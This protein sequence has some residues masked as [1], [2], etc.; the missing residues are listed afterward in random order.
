M[1]VKPP[2]KEVDRE[3]VKELEEALVDTVT[4][5]AV[6]VS[7]ITK[8][9]EDQEI[10][11]NKKRVKA[12]R[13]PRPLKWAGST[14]KVDII[15]GL[16]FK[17]FSIERVMKY[18]VILFLPLKPWVTARNETFF[19][20]GNIYPGADEEDIVFFR[21]LWKI[22][23]AMTKAEK[24]TIWKFWDTQIGIVEDWLEAT[25]WVVNDKERLVIPDIDYVEEAKR[26][27]ALV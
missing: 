27:G 23:N 3:Y 10:A 24:D 7:T 12:G 17:L 18:N 15:S 8:S 20:K 4:R 1:D 26:V 19:L 21:N 14:A 6:F 13:N 9:L 2:T 25:G 5:C 16:I 22:P 11:Q